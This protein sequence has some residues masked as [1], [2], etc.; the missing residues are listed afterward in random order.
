MD[1]HV[2]KTIPCQQKSGVRN[3]FKTKKKIAGM[4]FKKKIQGRKPKCAQIIG[5]KCIFKPLGYTNL[6]PLTLTK[7]VCHDFICSKSTNQNGVNRQLPPEI[8]S[9]VNY[10]LEINKTSIIPLKLHNVNQ[11]TPS[12][13]FFS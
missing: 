1:C 8:V 3:L 10:P 5:T 2:A 11:F 9:F 4:F 7:N 12:V 13:K 6:R